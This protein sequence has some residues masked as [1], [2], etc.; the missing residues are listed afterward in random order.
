M[1]SGPLLEKQSFSIGNLIKAHLPQ[2]TCQE[3]NFQLKKTLPAWRGSSCLLANQMKMEHNELKDIWTHYQ[4][5]IT[6]SV[7]R[8]PLIAHFLIFLS[9]EI[10]GST[11]IL[12]AFFDTISPS[13][14]SE[15]EHKLFQMHILLKNNSGRPFSHCPLA[16]HLLSMGPH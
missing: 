1:H 7:L 6:H 4:D 12:M 11:E 15:Y 2:R 9:S 10:T 16:K 13:A 8:W 5:N 3:F 14:V